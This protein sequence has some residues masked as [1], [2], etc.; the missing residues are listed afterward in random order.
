MQTDIINVSTTI[1][2]GI[3][4]IAIHAGDRRLFIRRDQLSR[5]IN[6]AAV[7][8][9]SFTRLRKLVY[10]THWRDMKEAPLGDEWIEGLNMRGEIEPM[11]RS[12][13]GW[14]GVGGEPVTP[15]MWRYG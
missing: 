1:A 11:C 2:S 8:G 13:D 12:G 4:G 3:D 9:A 7:V 5:E 10:G 15:L 6:E 14:C